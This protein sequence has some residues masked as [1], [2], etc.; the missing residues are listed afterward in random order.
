[1]KISDIIV[2]ADEPDQGRRNFLRGAGKIAA[3]GAAS[4]LGLLAKKANAGDPNDFVKESA[5]P[6]ASFYFD[7][8][9]QI[10]L[11][12]ETTFD[13]PHAITNTPPFNQLKQNEIKGTWGYITGK[14]IA[15]IANLNNQQWHSYIDTQMWHI[16]K[17]LS[18]QWQYCQ[19]LVNDTKDNIPPKTLRKMDE[20][21]K[22]ARKDIL[23]FYTKIVQEYNRVCASRPINNITQINPTLYKA[24]F[25]AGG[26]SNADPNQQVNQN[27]NLN[28]NVKLGYFEYGSRTPGHTYEGRMANGK[29]N[30]HGK[31]TWLYNSVSMGK[32]F[33]AGQYY[34]GSFV[35]DLPNGRGKFVSGMGS[36]RDY[37][38]EWR[39]GE[40]VR[41]SYY[42]VPNMNSNMAPSSDSDWKPMR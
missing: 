26:R 20:V 37:E 32:S 40:P 28:G 4:S 36:D 17:I 15:A 23:V 21:Y 8:C 6:V 30:G 16:G 33:Q 19:P 5:D 11:D 2:E 14:N 24:N 25:I 31:Y 12:F 39:N 18:L 34:E 27:A 35:D 9:V 22:N 41:R 13:T 42:A 1:M 3:A 29:R 38:G 10:A 7:I